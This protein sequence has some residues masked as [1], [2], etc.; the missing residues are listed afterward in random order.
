MFPLMVFSSL[1]KFLSSLVK[2]VSSIPNHLLNYGAEGEDEDE[3]EC[4]PSP[5]LVTFPVPFMAGSIKDRIP[6]VKLG[7]SRFMRLK[8]GDI[9]EEEEVCIVCL[10]MMKGS[11][12]VRELCNCCHVF[13]R[14]CVDAWIDEGH[15][16]CPLCRSK[17]VS[18]QDDQEEDGNGCGSDPWR[19]ERM[20]YLFGEDFDLVT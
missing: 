10:R 20:I 7:N 18:I 12:Q 17:L 5:L 11:D 8:K 1:N 9:D 16:T 14:E 15:K 2:D 3:E 19:R 6:V 13:H 4:R